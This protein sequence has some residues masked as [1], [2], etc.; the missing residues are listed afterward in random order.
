[1]LAAAVAAMAAF[2]LIPVGY[3]VIS[4]AQTGAARL[5]QLLLR[6]RVAE[7]TVNTVL[8]VVL[9]I[10]AALV[11]GIGGAWLVERTVM[12]LRRVFAVAL[13]APLA[14]PAFVM[15]YGWATVAPG[16]DGL[17]GAV[18]ISACAYS[19]LVYLPAVAALR[20]LDPALEESARSL[21]LGPWRVFL[22]VVLPQLRL[23]ALGGGLVVGLHLLAEYGAFA[24]LQFDTFTTAIMVAYQ[25][26]FG[27]ANAAA[28]GIVLTGLC[29]VLVLAETRM[30]GGARLSRT[31]ANRPATRAALG[32]WAVPAVIGLLAF[33]CAALIVP[34]SSVLRWGLRTDAGDW[35][36]VTPAAVQTVLL[37][38]GAALACAAV[39]LPVAWLAVRHR[40][41]LSMMLEGGFYL[42]GSLPA[43]IVALALVGVALQAAPGLYQTAAT[44][45]AAYVILFLP[46][47][48]VPL[49]AGLAQIPPEWEEAAR[50]LGTPPMLARLR[51]TAP[52]LAPAVASGAAL[53]A[54][55]AA[56]ELTATLLLAPI[57]TETIATGFWSA[58][59][60]IDYIAAAPY[61]LTLIVISV[62]AVHLMFTEAT[63]RGSA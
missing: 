50:S 20:G 24:F 52:L 49:R 16:L 34:L 7:L 25:S 15:S 26:N 55:G 13:A 47:I 23:A 1:M 54:L 41:R 39:A 22:R 61:A 56:N 3:V 62:P 27:G 4:S 8:L 45:I 6:P 28:L 2:A 37:A 38:V 17:G 21:G 51:V 32:P 12:P 57:G 43:I 58:A 36:A 53:V 35:A 11:I 30:R 46:R 5:A 31:A 18:L 40:R 63:S 48:L 19:P 42:A 60:A 44:A 33:I 10:G 59:S 29:L 9:G 14:V